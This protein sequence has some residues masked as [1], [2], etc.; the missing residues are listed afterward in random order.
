[1]IFYMWN[2]GQTNTEEWTL[3]PGNFD[4]L[5][6]NLQLNHK[7]MNLHSSQKSRSKLKQTQE[8]KS[9]SKSFHHSSPPKLNVDGEALRLF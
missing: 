9:L 2:W 4:N 8:A 1:M 5:Y 7:Y 3:D 6:N